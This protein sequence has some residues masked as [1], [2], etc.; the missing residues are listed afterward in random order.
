M[1]AFLSY[2]AEQH[3]RPRATAAHTGAEAAANVPRPVSPDEAIELA[4]NA[5]E[6]ASEPWLAARDL[7]ILLL[8]YGAGLRVAE[9]LA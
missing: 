6:A 7:A 9:A 8:L 1:R 2:A 4:E 5:A 3:G